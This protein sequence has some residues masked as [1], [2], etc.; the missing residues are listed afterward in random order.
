MMMSIYMNC[1]QGI[2]VQLPLNHNTG[3]KGATVN[4]PHTLFPAFAMKSCG[5]G[6]DGFISYSLKEIELPPK[7]SAKPCE[8]GL[9]AQ[10]SL[11]DFEQLG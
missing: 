1:I 5:N 4:A 8:D 10:F 9:H 3:A 6:C 11:H 2:Y 7:L